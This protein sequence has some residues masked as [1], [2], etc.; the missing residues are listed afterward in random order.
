MAHKPNP[1]A[2]DLSDVDNPTVGKAESMRPAC[3]LGDARKA[4]ATGAKI[5]A[6]EQNG[7][8]ISE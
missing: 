5:A 8:F 7:W 2:T 1:D 4:S 3:G 6:E